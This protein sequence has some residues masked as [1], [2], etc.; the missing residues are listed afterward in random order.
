MQHQQRFSSPFS[1]VYPF[2]FHEEDVVISLFSW[3]R[4]S[5]SI[6]GLIFYSVF[7]CP[8]VD[9]EDNNLI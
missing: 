1:G 6:T 4:H 2:C 9:Y 3:V 8:Q 5:S 7:M